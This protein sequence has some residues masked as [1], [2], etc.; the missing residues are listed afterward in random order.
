MRDFFFYPFAGL[1]ILG[2][3]GVVTHRKPTRALLLL[4][5]TMFSLAV[6]FLLLQAYFVAMVHLV[7]YAGAVLV[8]FLFVIM[9]LGIG[10]KEPNPEKYFKKVFLGFSAFVPL[11]FLGFLFYLAMTMDGRLLQPAEGNPAA[12]GKLLF[13]QYLLPFELVSFLLLIGVFAAVALARP[14]S[15]G[16]T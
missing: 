12:F 8:L 15:A 5:L 1:A 14:Q 6:L 10:A 9:L 13:T 2:A 16:K 4:I 11:A 7:V 3:L